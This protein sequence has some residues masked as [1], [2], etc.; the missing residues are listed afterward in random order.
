MNNSKKHGL[1]VVH[2]QG[3]RF[4][5]EGRCKNKAAL[6]ELTITGQGSTVSVLGVG[7][8]DNALCKVTL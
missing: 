2:G 4:E 1:P 6:E 7:G 8:G 3:S 5:P